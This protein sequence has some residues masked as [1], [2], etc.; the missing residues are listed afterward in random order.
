MSLHEWP[1]R[2]LR[3]RR[4]DPAKAHDQFAKTEAWRKENDVDNLYA[5][6]PTDEMQRAKLFYPRWTGRR[7]KVRHYP[8][9]ISELYTEVII[10]RS[11]G[12]RIQT[13]IVR[14]HDAE[15][16]EC[17]VGKKAV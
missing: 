3:A 12:L 14:R 5:T 8:W 10:A 17:D 2:F 16:I 11:A 13:G 4:Y 1:S 7:D 9:P 6:F 15:G